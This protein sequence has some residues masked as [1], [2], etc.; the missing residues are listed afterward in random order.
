MSER[1]LLRIL[2]VY[3]MMAA[4]TIRGLDSLLLVRHS[5]CDAVGLWKGLGNERL[6]GGF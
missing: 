6:N 2:V 4:M 3:R 5:P 1:Y